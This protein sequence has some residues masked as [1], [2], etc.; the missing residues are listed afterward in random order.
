MIPALNW[1]G[2]SVTTE[3]KASLEYTVRLPQQKRTI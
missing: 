3:F 2:Y 1:L